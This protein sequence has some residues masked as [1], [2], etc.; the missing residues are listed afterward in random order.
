[1]VGRSFS[2]NGDIDFHYDKKLNGTSI[3]GVVT[4]LSDRKLRG[5]LR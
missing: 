4:D 3:S 5:R 2:G 1:M